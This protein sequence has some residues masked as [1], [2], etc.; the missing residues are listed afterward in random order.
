MASRA[1]IR[2][3]AAVL[4]ALLDHHPEGIPAMI[5]FLT[6]KFSG[7]GCEPVGNSLIMTPRS[8]TP[9]RL[10]SRA[11]SRAAIQGVMV[12]ASQERE[13]SGSMDEL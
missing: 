9:I 7:T 2:L 8:R 12:R 4:L 3:G 10:S 13:A 5:R 11:E 6:G 1:E